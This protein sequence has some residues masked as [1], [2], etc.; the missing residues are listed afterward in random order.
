[1][2][3]LNNSLDISKIKQNVKDQTDILKL[4]NNRIQANNRLSTVR[5]YISDENKQIE[6]WGKIQYKNELQNY[7]NVEEKKC[8]GR[9]DTMLTNVII[10]K[11]IVL[12]ILLITNF[13]LEN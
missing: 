12:Y 7:K 8:V 11:P 1:M 4:H 6:K 9:T 2:R 13:I 5:Q 10:I 3:N